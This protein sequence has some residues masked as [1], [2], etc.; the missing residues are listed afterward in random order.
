MPL[1]LRSRNLKPLVR[2]GLLEVS[3][4]G[5]GRTRLVRISPE[6]KRALDA[7]YPMWQ[8]AQEEVVG[9]LGKERYE[10]LLGDVGRTVAIA[11]D[12]PL[13]ASNGTGGGAV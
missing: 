10:A 1:L 12:R 5:D 4:G 13:E 8:V 7:A 3:P 11:A 6:G 9:A 2:E